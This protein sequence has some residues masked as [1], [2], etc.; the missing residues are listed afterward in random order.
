MEAL[1]FP[2]E[3]NSCLYVANEKRRLGN[4]LPPCRPLGGVSETHETLQCVNA[5]SA[6]EAGPPSVSAS[7]IKEA[8]FYLSAHYEVPDGEWSLHTSSVSLLPRDLIVFYSLSLALSLCLAFM[9]N[10]VGT[11]QLL[12]FAYVFYTLCYGY[13]YAEI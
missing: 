13:K 2:K 7:V 3:K 8:D 12:M 1:H 4:E 5:H 10:T 9:F 11:N 6:S